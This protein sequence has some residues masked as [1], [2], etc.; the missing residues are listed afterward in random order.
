MARREVHQAGTG[1]CAERNP[2]PW[3]AGV[4]D[5]HDEPRR[6]SPE[7]YVKRIHRVGAG[8]CK[9]PGGNGD[10]HGSQQLREAPAAQLTG[11]GCCHE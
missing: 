5:P 1:D 9:V 7:Q 11:Y 6:E 10:A 3:V 4:D 2:Q 8:G